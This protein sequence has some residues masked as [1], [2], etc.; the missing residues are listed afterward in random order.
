MLIAPPAAVAEHR[1]AAL[2]DEVAHAAVG[3]LDVDRVDGQH[4][5]LGG[6]AHARLVQEGLHGDD[7]AAE[8]AHDREGMRAEGLQVRIGHLPLLRHHLV[9]AGLGAVE[10]HLVD[11]V[12]QLAHLA[13]QLALLRVLGGLGEVV[14]QVAAQIQLVLRSVGHQLAGLAHVGADGLLAQHGLLVVQRDHGRLKVHGAVLI[15]GG[16]DRN[17][18]DLGHGLQHFL[19]AVEGA[20]MEFLG[21]LVGLFLNQVAHGH[22]VGQGVVEVALGVGIADAAHTDDCNIQCHG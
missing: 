2:G 16:G 5:V 14:V 19:F 3:E 21:G 11:A 1:V 13:V 9:V 17:H 22:Q 7:V 10:A 12:N 8:V 15:A 4:R 6:A 20:A 18:V